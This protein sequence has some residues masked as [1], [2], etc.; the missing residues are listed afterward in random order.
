MALNCYSPPF[1][2]GNTWAWPDLPTQRVRW[3][4]GKQEHWMY[5]L[6]W[7][8][9]PP[10][11][12]YQCSCVSR[13]VFESQ[14]L[15]FHLKT[16]NYMAH[17]T[18]PDP[19]SSHNTGEKTGG[20]ANWNQMWWSSTAG[21]TKCNM[22]RRISVEDL[23]KPASLNSMTHWC[24]SV[25]VLCPVA[26]RS[27]RYKLLTYMSGVINHILAIINYIAHMWAW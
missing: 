18:K 4:Q 21:C 13:W 27:D 3:E 16:K 8:I 23:R 7:A 24:Q 10:W 6:R 20:E 26:F 17:L 15:L 14:H 2:V 12:V 1:S 5:C 11:K 19:D 9:E 22:P 25:P